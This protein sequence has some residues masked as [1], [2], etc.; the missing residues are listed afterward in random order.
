MYFL[1]FF[2]ILVYI[3]IFSLV[4]FLVYCLFWVLLIDREVWGFRCGGWGVIYRKSKWNDRKVLIYSIK[5]K[6]LN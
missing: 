3:Y 2:Y 1:V 5:K 6:Y 4:M